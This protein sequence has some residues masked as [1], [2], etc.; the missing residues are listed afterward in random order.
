M[1]FSDEHTREG[2]RFDLGA[3]WARFLLNLN[4]DRIR[5]AE[6]SQTQMLDVEDPAGT[7]FLGLGSGSDLFSLAARRLGARVR[8]FDGGRSRTALGRCGR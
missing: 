1:T 5:L 6:R 8:S 3:N 4:D 7:S 2:K